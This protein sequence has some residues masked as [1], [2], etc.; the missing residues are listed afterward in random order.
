LAADV[1][2]YARLMGRDESGTL[3]RLK[4]HRRERLEPALARNS[5]RL[6][7]LT[8][9]GALVEFGS[10]VDALRAAIEIQQAV[11]DVNRDRPDEH[12]IEFRIGMHVGDLIVDG[13]DLYG[14]AVNI[15]ARLETEAMPGGI[16]VSRAVRDA[17]EGRLDAKL[18]ALGE[19]VLK[20]IGRPVRAFRVEW[21]GD[22]WRAQALAEFGSAISSTPVLALPDKPSI[23]VLP[24]QNIGG[25][26]EQEY[27]AD[28][29]VE[30]IITSLSRFRSLFVIA[31]NS[32]FAYK[33]R[34]PDVRQ[35]GHELGVR[36]VL[37][38]SV[39][40]AGVR[41]RITGQ[42]VDAA[43][44][45]H[46]WADRFDGELADVFELQDRVTSSVVA[47]IAP[48]VERAELERARC[49]PTGSLQAY[50]KVLRA[51]ALERSR[52]RSDLEEAI[53]ILR[54]VIRSD[55]EYARAYAQLSRVCWVY[56]GQGYGHRDHALVS[57]FAALAQRGLELDPT[58]A[59]VMVIAALAIAYAGG[60]IQAGLDLVEKAIR[61]NPN[62]AGA[63][64]AGGVLNSYLGEV[65]RAL[66]CIQ[67][68]DRLNPLAASFSANDVRFIASFGV[69]DH[70]AVVDETARGLREHSNSGPALRYRAASLA[71][72]G[73][74]EEARQVVGRLIAA[75]PG[76]CIAEVR[77]HYEFDLNN[78]FK[79]PGVTESLYR[80]LRLAGLPE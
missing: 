48:M 37:E 45:V 3:A 33:G 22:A 70:E 10:A 27:F 65:D 5:G 56:V 66:E 40:K 2:G 80:G 71:L 6:V 72:L 77:R 67:H 30:D 14:D 11:F 41:V 79:K 64:L 76:Y 51:V 9:D 58:D 50:D 39:R 15:A 52:A 38:G 26:P 53:R 36:Y 75:R 69:G 57:D 35:V 73:R 21:D 13:G 60:D 24:F 20:N 47:I 31:R 8:G 61:L 44:R 12:R 59:H 49:K 7:K 68:A 1:V 32:S 34:S 28:G 18:H 54:E 17:V 78:P 42:L 23:A 46:L 19:L 16:I 25:D 63:Y 55:P 4:E 43:N 74:I 29:M 62:F